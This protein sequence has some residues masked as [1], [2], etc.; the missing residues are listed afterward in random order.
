METTLHLHLA[1]NTMRDGNG[2]FVQGSP[3]FT[4][5]A[6]KDF[7]KHILDKGLQIP[8]VS[9]SRKFGGC[10][11]PI[12]ELEGHNYHVPTFDNEDDMLEYCNRI[13]NAVKQ[14][15]VYVKAKLKMDD[16]TEKDGSVT[17]A[18]EN[19]GVKLGFGDYVAVPVE[20]NTGVS[21]AGFCME[22]GKSEDEVGA[23]Q[24]GENMCKECYKNHKENGND[25]PW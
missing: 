20:E 3:Q 16:N 7:V 23:N 5:T 13:I 21:L 9:C 18:Q 6:S 17:L 25:L 1:V 2:N 22:C 14:E 10:V 24:E 11:Y 4:T 15:C 12:T 8:T 19:I